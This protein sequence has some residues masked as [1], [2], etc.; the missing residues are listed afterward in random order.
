MLRNGELLIRA[1]KFLTTRV[2]LEII[3]WNVFLTVE[4]DTHRR[5]WL[6]VLRITRITDW[7]TDRVVL[8]RERLRKVRALP[9]PSRSMRARLLLGFSSRLWRCR[10]RAI[11]N[12]FCCVF[13]A[14]SILIM[15]SRRILARVLALL[16]DIDVHQSN[17]RF[18]ETVPALCFLRGPLSLW[19]SLHDVLH[20]LRDRRRCW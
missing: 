6:W 3:L 7:S 1:G 16:A 10:A 18:R 13:I 20:S 5:A 4:H 15:L 9:W 17:G 8:F 12:L 11:R 2:L 19:G 14:G